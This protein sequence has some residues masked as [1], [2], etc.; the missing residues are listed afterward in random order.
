MS[1]ESF[2]K[3]TRRRRK[4]TKEEKEMLVRHDNALVLL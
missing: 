4:F 3:K 1:F 2:K